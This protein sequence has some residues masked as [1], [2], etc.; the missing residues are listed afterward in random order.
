M[1][2]NTWAGLWRVFFSNLIEKLV[3]R[4]P[5]DE[6][7]EILHECKFCMTSQCVRFSLPGYVSRARCAQC[8][9][10]WRVQLASVCLS[11]TGMGTES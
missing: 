10:P 5:G 2:N 1:R 7:F 6:L 4:I 3:T 9:C 8:C 11:V